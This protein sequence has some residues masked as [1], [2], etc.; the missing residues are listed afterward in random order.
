MKQLK[1]ITRWISAIF[2]LAF[3]G[4]QVVPVDRT[5]PPVETEVPA[6][7]EVRSILRRACY[8]CHSHET[9]WPWYSRVAPVSWLIER[10]VRKGREELN[11]S[12]WNRYSTKQQIKKMKESWD[13]VS[14]GDMPPWFYL[15]PHPDARLSKNDLAALETW[16]RSIV[17]DKPRPHN[18]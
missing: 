6:I 17:N 12:T 3:I 4:I 1:F 16:S 10:D 2:L 11:L 13:Q 7:P 15:L 14:D 8:D 18:R 5:N 9:V